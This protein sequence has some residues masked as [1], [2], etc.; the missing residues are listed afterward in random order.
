[1][2]NRTGIL[3]TSAGAFF[4]LFPMLALPLVA[5][6]N[7]D[8][9]VQALAD[10]AGRCFHVQV[11]VQ[12]GSS[13]ETEQ[14]CGAARTSIELLASCGLRTTAPI[15]VMVSDHVY[16]GSIAKRWGEYLPGTSRVNV[17]T[18]ATHGKS[19]NFN[20]YDT[21]MPAAEHFAG[22]VAHEIAHAVFYDATKELDL[23]ETAHEYVAYVIQLMSFS[24]ETR[25]RIVALAQPNPTA[26]L[27]VFSHFLRL[28]DPHRFGVNA[29]AHFVR[30]E[31]GC[32]FLTAV[33]AGHVHFPP[34]SD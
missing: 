20:F 12:F 19:S 31:N 26:S 18:V 34:P 17:L 27:F 29:Y 15:F 22:I 33:I 14:V 10:A 32:A 11:K 13:S 2:L 23:P 7:P 16:L 6:E 21:N 24:E 3:W 8:T 30:P 28:A 1:M 5:Q 25:R 9:P 4:L